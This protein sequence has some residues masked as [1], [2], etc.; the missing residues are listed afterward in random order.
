MTPHELLDQILKKRRRTLTLILTAVVSIGLVV[1][2]LSM[3]KIEDLLSALLNVHLST[4]YLALAVAI[5]GN[6]VRAYRWKVLLGDR[7]MGLMDLFW[8]NLVR[9]L[10]VNIV[11][12][13][14]GSLS[15]IYVLFQRFKIPVE[16]GLSTMVVG[17]V[18][19]SVAMLPPDFFCSGFPG[20]G[21]PGLLPRGPGV[22]HRG[23]VYPLD[24]GADLFSSP[25][26]YRYQGA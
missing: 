7:K 24:V 9:D 15:H 20:S 8:F 23:S 13:R 6:L 2:L 5:L 25:G 3:I 19:D 16:I 22:C 1:L 17:L 10:F 21:E 12:A 11:P 4:L 26:G 14:L 18:F